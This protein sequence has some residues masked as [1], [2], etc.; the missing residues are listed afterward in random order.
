M[1]KKQKEAL[2]RGNWEV[3]NGFTMPAYRR[4]PSGE[5]QLIVLSP[6]KSMW[7]LLGVG[8]EVFSH[9]SLFIVL[10]EANRRSF[11]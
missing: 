6:D 2:D 11:S 4:K 3:D 10:I 8:T 9:K 5:S 7:R 1:N